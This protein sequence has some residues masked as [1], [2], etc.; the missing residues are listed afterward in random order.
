LTW[1]F[2]ITSPRRIAIGDDFH[3]NK[4]TL[5]STALEELR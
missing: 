5:I 1:W 3:E 4:L 2:Y